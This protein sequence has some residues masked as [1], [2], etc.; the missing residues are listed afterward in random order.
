MDSRD[1]DEHLSR[2]KTRWSLVFQAH[3]GTPD[4]GGTAQRELL[5]RYYGAV[6]RY[7]RGMLRDSAAAEELTQDFAV[8]FLRGDFRN[9]DPQRGRFRDFLKTTVR[10]LV[11]DHWRQQAHHK[12]DDRPLPADS[13]VGPAAP[14]AGAESDAAFLASWRE[15]LLARTWEGLAQFQKESGSPYH[16]VLRHKTEQPQVRAAQLAE[17]LSAQFGRPFTETSVRQVLHRARE[18]FADLLL[19]EVAC[20]LPSPTTEELEQ[21]LID[22]GLLDYCESALK[23]R[24]A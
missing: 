20:S 9:A 18:K 5:L 6:Y 13:G 4:P 7:L 11:I 1:L 14:E 21:E 19:E 23:R 15:E 22:L 16:T 8:R 24:G 2:I 10:H 3:Q 12:E 17:T